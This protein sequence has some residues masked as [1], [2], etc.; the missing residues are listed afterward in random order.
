M[1]NLV[2]PLTSAS[3]AMA[4]KQRLQQQDSKINY[5]MTLYLH[6]KISPAVVK[7]A[8]A[9]GV[10]GIKSYPAGVTTNSSS[11]V[12]DYEVFYPVFRAMEQCGMVLN[13]H[14]EC[15]S[16]HGKNITVLNSESSFLP[17]LKSLHA[18]FPKASYP[19]RLRTKVALRRC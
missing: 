2:P 10:V 12:L 13:L 15:P 11:G 19:L 3:D 1:P 7:G 6:E 8:K 16:D 9:Q 17:T 14:G 4:Y 5:L 18:Q